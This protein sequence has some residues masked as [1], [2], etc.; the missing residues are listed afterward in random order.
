MI[1]HVT[2]R[3]GLFKYERSQGL[4]YHI[5][6]PYAIETYKHDQVTY[7]RPFFLSQGIY[8]TVSETEPRNEKNVFSASA[9]AFRSFE[10]FTFAC[11]QGTG[12]NDDRPSLEWAGLTIQLKELE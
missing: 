5:M 4:F 6:I 11:K 9:S 10:H 1:T 7:M 3:L 8:F 12:T 2:V